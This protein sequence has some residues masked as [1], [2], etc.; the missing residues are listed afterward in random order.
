MR[1]EAVNH[2]AH[3]VYHLEFQEGKVI[4]LR[5]WNLATN[6]DILCV[7]RDTYKR[8]SEV[9]EDAIATL[10]HDRNFEDFAKLFTAMCDDEEYCNRAR[11]VIA[12]EL[13]CMAKQVERITLQYWL[14]DL[15]S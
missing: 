2:P 4:G 10:C 6:E 15:K 8:F 11:K 3:T 12:E 14:E 13:M 1:I 5:Y 9:F 7:K